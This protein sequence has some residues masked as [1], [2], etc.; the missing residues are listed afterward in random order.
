MRRVRPTERQPAGIPAGG[1]FA[2]HARTGAAVSLATSAVFDS[3]TMSPLAGTP[4]SSRDWDFISLD[5]LG[6]SNLWRYSSGDHLE[7]VS[8]GGW[9]GVEVTPENEGWV[10]TSG[11]CDIWAAAATRQRGWPVW[12]AGHECAGC[13]SEMNYGFREGDFYDELGL[14]EC[15]TAH[16]FVQAPDGMLWDVHGEHDPLGV[17]ES[18]RS[19]L[20]PVTEAT[21]SDVLDSWH[22]PDDADVVAWAHLSVDRVLPPPCGECDDQGWVAAPAHHCAGSGMCN[23]QCGMPVQEECPSCARPAPTSAIEVP[24]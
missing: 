19:P 20:R 11:A 22:G 7:E 6:N 21:L 24:F 2:P 1:E 14:C 4:I 15:Q 5:Q 3:A 10:F 12:A 9:R 8:R 16:F 17:A 13:D 23:E 18:Y